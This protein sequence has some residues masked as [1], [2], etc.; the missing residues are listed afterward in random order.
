M[1]LRKRVVFVTAARKGLRNCTVLRIGKM[2]KIDTIVGWMIY[3]KEMQ[4]IG[5]LTY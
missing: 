5:S 2:N 3:A 4:L 1:L